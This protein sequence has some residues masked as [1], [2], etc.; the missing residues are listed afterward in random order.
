MNLS[1][2]SLSDYISTIVASNDQ[3]AADFKIARTETT[4]RIDDGITTEHTITSFEF[5][6]GVV[7]RK[8][9]NLI[10]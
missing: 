3:D 1:T 7:I 6:D 8:K 5:S 4:M 2:K 10:T 9:L